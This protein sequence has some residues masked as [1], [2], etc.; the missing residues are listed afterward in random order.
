[1]IFAAATAAASAAFARALDAFP[2]NERVTD[3][4]AAVLR[5]ALEAPGADAAAVLEVV[6]RALRVPL[7]P[8]A[9]GMLLDMVTRLAERNITSD[10]LPDALGDEG[11]ECLDRARRAHAG[12]VARRAAAAARRAA[13]TARVGEVVA[14]ARRLHDVIR[15]RGAR[16]GIIA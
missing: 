9:R 11:G 5:C 7:S 2:T 8:R 16:P 13:Y 1:M 6:V 14:R 3:Q 15:E 10:A 4:G 12:A